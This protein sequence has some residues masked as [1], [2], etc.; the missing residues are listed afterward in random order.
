MPPSTQQQPRGNDRADRTRLAPKPPAPRIA[1]AP[2]IEGM[3]GEFGGM[4][5]EETVRPL[6]ETLVLAYGQFRGDPR[7]HEQAADAAKLWLL[8]PTPLQQASRLTAHVRARAG[9]GF[10]ATIWLKRED[11]THSDSAA[12]ASAL[13]QAHFASWLGRKHLLAACVSPGHAVAAA[14]AANWHQLACEV[15][16][17]RSVIDACG[18]QLATLGASTT[19][20]GQDAIDAVLDRWSAGPDAG[21][22][23][24]PGVCAPH[25]FPTIV[26]DGA[27]CV[28]RETLAQSLR[29]FS[30][31]PQAVVAHIGHGTLAAGLFHAFVDEPKVK[32]V[33]VES[34]GRG[35]DT[36]E[37]AAPLCYGI[38]GVAHGCLG[39][40]LQDAFGN[41]SPLQADAGLMRVGDAGP[42]LAWWK[43][44]GRLESTNT[45]DTECGESR[46]LLARCEGIIPSR[47][48][49]HAVAFAQSL[50]AQMPE[51]EHLVVAVTRED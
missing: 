2:G 41:P 35:P 5:A 3:F 14:R 9:K 11:L 19:P 22:P 17:P 4:F 24:L 40:V 37:H 34:G 33:G 29:A 18:D 26:R 47:S 7:V 49:A 27:R 6:Y 48:S 1:D 21:L 28:G 51:G 45:S 12:L 30:L 36:G 13:H 20:T 42:E 31:L 44:L 10:G 23:I 8:R 39:I 16:A 43:S 25:P 38:K 15:V 32:L 50:A 46:Q